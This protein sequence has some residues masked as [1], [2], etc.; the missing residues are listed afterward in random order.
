MGNIGTIT[1]ACGGTFYDSG[2][3]VGNYGNSQFFTA[4]FCAP[5]GQY[6]TFNFTSFNTEFLF[7]WLDVYNGPTTGSPLIGSYTGAISPGTVTS[8]LG[9]CITFVFE[10]DISDVAPGWTATISCNTAPPSTGN[11]CGTSLPFC[12]GTSY[13]FPNNTDQADLGPMDCLL[14]TPN[15]VW[16]YMQI[17]NPGNLNINISQSDAFGFGI[18]VD[19]DLWGPFNTLS[20][21]CVAIANGTAT[22]VDCSFSPAFVEQANIVGAT[23]GQ[24]YI[25]LLTNFSNEP[26]TISFNSASGSTATT[27]CGLL[28]NITD[29]TANPSACVPATNTYSVTGQV[30]VANPPATGSLLINS[31]CGGSVTI[32]APFISPI[33][34]TLPGIIATGTSCN[35]TASFSADPSCSFTQSYTAP[36]SCAS[37]I[38]N[39]PGYASTSSSPNNACAGQVYYFDVANTACNGTISFN[40]VGNYGSAYANEITW[41]V[42]SNLTGLPVPGAVGGPGVNGANFNF[43]IGPINPA[44]YGSIFTLYVFDSFGDGF[45]GVGGTISVV[46]NATT[47][48]GPIVG[49]FLAQGST[50]FGANI[51]ISPAT[52]TIN[53]PTGPVT[54]TVN[55]CNNFSVPITLQNTNFCNTI[56]INLPFTIVCQ[57]TGAII[58]SGTKN[59]TIYPSIPTA[60]SDLIDITFNSATCTWSMTPQND[61]IAANIGSIFT[62]SPN[63][64]SI[65]TAACTGGNETFTVTYNGIAA[66][67]NCCSTGGPLIP[68]VYNQT[69]NQSNVVAGTSPFWITTNHAAVLTIPPYNT[70]GTANSLTFTLNVNNYCYNQPGANFPIATSYWVTIVVNG[71]I[72]YDQVTANPAPVNN[73]VTINLANLANGYNQNSTIQVYIYPNT[74]TSTVFNPVSACPPPID[75]QWTAQVSSTINASFN[76]LQPTPA[77]CTFS[78]FLPFNCCSFN[79]IADAF[80]TICN[81]SPLTSLTAWQNS[82]ALANT[83]CVVYSSVPP[84]AGSVTPDNILPSGI[85]LTSNPVLQTVGAYV[86]CDTDGSGNINAGDTYNLVSTFVLTVNPIA[87]AV[88]SGTT[89]ICGGTGTSITFNGTPN[90]TVVYIINGG[91]NQT[92]TLDGSGN[93]TLPTGNL[94]VTTTFALVSVSIPGPP[95]CNQNVAGTAVVTIIPPP[96]ATFTYPTPICKNVPNP[97]PTFTGGGVAGIFSATPAGLNFVNTS[98]GE[99]NL[100]TTPAGNYTIT[101]TIPA[102]GG[103]PSVIANFDLVI[104]AAGTVSIISIPASA[105]TCF[106]VS[107]VTLTVNPNTFSSYSWSPA[108]GLSGAI[109]FSVAAFPAAPTTYTVVATAA[110]GCTASASLLVNVSTPSNAGTNGNITLCSTGIPVNLFSSLGGTPQSTGTWTGPSALTGGN[111]GTFTPGVNVAGTYTY[112]VIGTAPCPNATATVTVVQNLAPNAGSNGSISLCSNSSITSLFGILGGTP[113]AIGT[114]T[115]PS[116]LPGGNLGNFNPAVHTPGLYTYTV[117]GI[118]PC[119]NASA[120]VNV[121]VNPATNAGTGGTVTLCYTSPPTNLFPT[122]GGL[123]QP[124]GIW[125]GPSALTGGHLGTFT[126]SV[127]IPGIYT[128]TVAGIA[129]CPNASTNVIVNVNPE[130]IVAISGSTT[131]CAGSSTNINFVGTPNAI[132]TYNVN[133]GPNTVIVLN[134]AGNATLATGPLAVTTNYNLLVI[135]MPGPICA[136]LVSGTATVTIVPAPT[137]TISGTTTICAG[138]STTINF[139]GTPNATVT[140]TVNGGSNQTVL[141]DGAG[142]ASISTGNLN[143][144]A[145]YTLVDISLPGPPVCSQSAS[146]SAVIT[147][148]PPSLTSLTYPGAPYCSNFVG[149][150]N[151]VIAGVTGGTYTSNPIGLTINGAG[152]ITPSTSSP[153]TYIVTYQVPASGG[154]LAYDV[155][156]TVVINALPAAPTLLPNPACAGQPINFTAGGGSLYEFILNGVSQGAPSSTNTITLGPLNVGDQ[157]CVNSYPALPINFNGLIT[158]AEWGSPLSTSTG[159]PAASGFGVNNNLD[160]IYLK[161]SSGYFYGALAGNVA[162]GSNNRLLLFIDCQ[163]GG[164]NSLATWSNRS[165]VPYISLENLNSSITFDAGFTA[166]YILAMNQATADSYFDLYNMT[167]NT[168][169]YLGSG[170]TSPLLGFV[171]NSGTGDYS[172]GFEFG[173][174][175]TALGNP[176]VSV[177]VFAMLVNDPGFGITPTTISNQFLT[178]CG[179]AEINYGNGLINFAAAAPNPIQFPLSADCFS[180][181]CITV[182]NSV[183]PTFSFPTS[184]CNGTLAPTLPLI[185]DNGVAG[186]WSPSTINNSASA[187][188]TFTPSGGCAIPITVNI[189]IAPNPIISPLFHD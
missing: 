117:T 34:Y 182:A 48:A 9:G 94:A 163:P 12:T 19:F 2:G 112:T 67:P 120:T 126:P 29:V 151:P 100:T 26:G 150:V 71:S 115:G 177:K 122:L 160:A 97:F 172:K 86:Y 64:A 91:A 175:M 134:A 181:T 52:I 128:Y 111:L 165:G 27:N 28:C 66:G 101:N 31:N 70:G 130:Q 4:T 116:V 108:A 158:E 138:N 78:P 137:V 168:N 5:P 18:D 178:P 33:N 162:N 65:S 57:S 132:V 98:T 142:N 43:A 63:P 140:Y 87:T 131:L 170:N 15:P 45:N 146:G 80:A 36:A 144:S 119:A 107:S 99:I 68:I 109:G 118:A 185:S 20:D 121:T 161:N 10:S 41:A 147:V 173:I 62:V 155:N 77:V 35:I 3:P 46:Q 8:T 127:S 22:S 83:Q 1:N 141:L 53:T 188:Y 157:V 124:I 92:I 6:I 32:N 152:V 166:D 180:Q 37:T 171:G 164:F 75:G 17:Q 82:V 102:S 123:S 47:I 159:G 13:I 167:A 58:S 106:G 50:M 88:I 54:S 44:V 145:T 110:N 133:G 113:Q 59:V 125:T 114:W 16:Y 61:C 129:P 136:A 187:S 149:N 72:V 30:I 56:N 25:L 39:C 135:Q 95:V 174:P 103:C 24:F 74:F 156:Q 89:S 153:G 93:A 14:S 55:G 183:T 73:S 69:F 11:D 169:N 186:T 84:V 154:C 96:I 85:N 40:V 51:A 176:S 79:T 76:N 148:N 60:A 189:T 105:T 139:T 21:G 7:D 104:N 90:A 184:I 81:G 179:A 143:A 38:L 49:N 23:T 42:Y